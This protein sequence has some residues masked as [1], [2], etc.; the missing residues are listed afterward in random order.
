MSSLVCLGGWL[1][2][3]NTA[4]SR[5]QDVEVAEDVSQ[6]TEYVSQVIEDNSQE[7]EDVSQVTED[8]SG[9]LGCVP[10]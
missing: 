1:E 4:D 7:T 3:L 9:N 8:V 10:R 5:V 6:V 2:G